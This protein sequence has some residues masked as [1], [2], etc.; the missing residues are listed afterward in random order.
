MDLTVTPHNITELQNRNN[1]SCNLILKKHEKKKTNP[2]EQS[3]SPDQNQE[4]KL[5]KAVLLP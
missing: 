2:A 3:D 1:P 5:E 4:Y